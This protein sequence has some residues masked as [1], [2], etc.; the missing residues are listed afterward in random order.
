[1]YDT[2]GAAAGLALTDK[3]GGG[4]SS[5]VLLLQLT[6]REV[7]CRLGLHEASENV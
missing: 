1:M 4:S 5:E 7:E 6:V 3:A 2:L